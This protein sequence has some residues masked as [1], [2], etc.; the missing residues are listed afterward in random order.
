VKLDPRL[1]KLFGYGLI[2]TGA[3]TAMSGVVNM[4]AAYQLIDD[5]DAASLGVSRNEFIITY[6]GF[7]IVGAAM[8]FLGWRLKREPP[9]KPPL[10]RRQ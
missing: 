6:A 10:H 9:P 5:A 4:I 7:L 2:G 1:K 8:I 3:L